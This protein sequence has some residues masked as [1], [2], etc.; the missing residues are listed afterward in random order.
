M[1]LISVA[2]GFVIGTLFGIGGALYYLKWKMNRQLGMMEEEMDQLME[3]TQGLSEGFE[4]IDGPKE[5]IQDMDEI[6]EP[7]EEQDSGQNKEDKE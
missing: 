6:P 4:D 2:V 7:S 5:Q 1:D 3:A